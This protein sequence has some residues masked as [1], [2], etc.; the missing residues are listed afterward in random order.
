MVLK[1]LSERGNMG[2]TDIGRHLQLPKSIVYRLLASL[3]AADL[4]RVEK[5]SRRYALGSGLLRMTAGWLG[6]IDVRSAAMPYLREL[7]QDT[8][9]TVALNIRERDQVVTI[10]RL[11]T[12]FEVRFVIDLCRPFPLYLG[13]AGKAIL[14]F[15]PIDEINQIMSWEELTAKDEKRVR[16]DLERIRQQGFADTCG[17]RVA[18]SRSISAP[19]LDHEG[20]A[21]ASVSIL[22]LE[23]RMQADEVIECG[24]LIKAVS[25]KIS[26]EMGFSARQSAA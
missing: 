5:T 19:I 12:S 2:V 1:T 25:Q 7:R 23:S 18:G 24:R 20:L 9:E 21:L 22:S 17:E 10:E 15:L 8:N 4:V 26:N 14:A 11:D 6:Q 13:A 3:L 16:E